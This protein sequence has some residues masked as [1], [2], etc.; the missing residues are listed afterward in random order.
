MSIGRENQLLKAI[1]DVLDYKSMLYIGINQVREEMLHLFKERDYDITIL[2]AWK[3][4]VDALKSK[5]PN[6]IWADVRD[7]DKIKFLPRFDIVMW[8]HG[9]EHIKE[10]ELPKILIE[11][12][13]KALLYIIIACP[14]GIYEQGNCSNPYEEHLAYLYPE[15]FKELGWQTD[16]IGKEDVKGSNLLAWKRI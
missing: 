4:N 13:M 10:R 1:P 15:F 14:W 11:L 6:I 3:S 8:W 2:E 12:R 9:P 16:T 5:Y 7:L